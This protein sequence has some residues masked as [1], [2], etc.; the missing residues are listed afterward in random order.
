MSHLSKAHTISN[1]IP[2][3]SKA[4][5]VPYERNSTVL[6]RWALQIIVTCPPIHW[7][8]FAFL[9][10][11]KATVNPACPDTEEFPPALLAQNCC[12]G[13][14]TTILQAPSISLDLEEEECGRISLHPSNFQMPEQPLWTS[15][16]RSE[17]KHS[18]AWDLDYPS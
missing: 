1:Q 18:E 11:C 14:H 10:W 3:A 2:F 15:G 8:N 17:L 13:S 16:R 5:I 7:G 9:H 12:S 4:S 6:L